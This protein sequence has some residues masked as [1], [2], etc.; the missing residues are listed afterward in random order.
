MSSMLNYFKRKLRP[1]CVGS[2]THSLDGSS[3]KEASEKKLANKLKNQSDAKLAGSKKRRLHMKLKHS[4]KSNLQ[5]LIGITISSSELKKRPDLNV[6]ASVT[7]NMTKLEETSSQSL[8]VTDDSKNVYTN[9]SYTSKYSKAL[10]STV[11]KEN[12]VCSSVDG[13]FLNSTSLGQT[14]SSGY[15][16]YATGG[17][18]NYCSNYTTDQHCVANLTVNS[19]ADSN[20]SMVTYNTKYANSRMSDDDGLMSVDGGETSSMH[21]SSISVSENIQQSTPYN[22][23]FARIR[24]LKIGK[25]QMKTR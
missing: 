18:S 19:A 23:N 9:C 13:D 10:A 11:A 17:S 3:V 25:N 12:F 7:Q 22:E 15:V 24:S 6:T 1:R 4:I 5:D 2:P 16:E 14:N 20:N 21:H 8:N